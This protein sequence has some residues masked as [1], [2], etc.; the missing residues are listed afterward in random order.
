MD[1]AF[2]RFI[3]P[4][5]NQQNEQDQGIAGNNVEISVVDGDVDRPVVMRGD[6]GNG[7]DHVSQVSRS[8]RIG[9][10]VSDGTS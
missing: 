10:S 1:D 4:L 8:F 2:N 5:D 3:K 9:Y 7:C 6:L